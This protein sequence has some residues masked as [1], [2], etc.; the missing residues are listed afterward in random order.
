MHSPPATITSKL[1]YTYV[2]LGG[3]PTV[4]GR[5]YKGRDALHASARAQNKIKWI[6]KQGALKDSR[7]VW[8]NSGWLSVTESNSGADSK[9]LTRA[10]AST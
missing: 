2:Y 3:E 7:S 5:S 8:S 4:F 10:S 9:A 6:S 1:V